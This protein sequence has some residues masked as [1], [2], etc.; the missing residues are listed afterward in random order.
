MC[1]S[2]VFE[3]FHMDDMSNN[4]SENRLCDELH[5]ADMAHYSKIEVLS[6]FLTIHAVYYYISTISIYQGQCELYTK[7][8]E[9]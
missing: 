6:L 5:L 2:R 8:K 1:H 9:K 4:I 7:E 3:T